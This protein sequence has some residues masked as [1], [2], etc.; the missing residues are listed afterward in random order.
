MNLYANYAL[1]IH[2]YKCNEGGGGGGVASDG[3]HS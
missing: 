1:E 2:C 3:G